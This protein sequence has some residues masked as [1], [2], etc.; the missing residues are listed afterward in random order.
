MSNSFSAAAAPV[1][2]DGDR[3]AG[4]AGFRSGEQ[5]LLADQRV[6]Q[7]R[8]AGVGPADDG[9]PHRLG[10]VIGRLGIGIGDVLADQR[11]ADRNLVVFLFVAEGALF[12]ERFD[13]GVAQLGQALAVLGRNADRLAEPKFPA[14]QQ[15]ALGAFRF[16]LVGD[17]H[18]RL[19]GFPDDLGKG[20]VVGRQA[21]LGVDHEEDQ[22]RLADRDLGLGAHAAL[23]RAGAPHPRSRRCR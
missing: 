7:G 3:I 2:V 14:F 8:L 20:P 18:D 6:D 19:A 5:A 12:A 10:V 9:D 1:P 13:D 4:D 15:P 22:I 17:Q 16:G 11:L 21:G 23:K